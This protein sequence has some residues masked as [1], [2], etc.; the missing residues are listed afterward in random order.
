MV[1]RQAAAVLRGVGLDRWICRDGAEMVEKA[2][3]LTSDRNGLKQQRLQQR[4]QI[5]NSELLDHAGLAAT[6]EGSFRHWWLRWLQQEG[7]PT[8][9]QQ[10]AWPQTSNQED[11]AL[12]TPVSNSVNKRLPLWL[13]Y[14]PDMERQRLEAQGKRVIALQN[15]HPWGEA[16]SSFAKYR[17]DDVLVWLETGASEESLRWWQ[18]TY[19]QLLWELRGPLAPR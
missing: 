18:Q 2:L 1:S 13:G 10:Q 11:R 9:V 8:D 19:P 6:L 15:L 4:Q 16:V 3:S 5:A 17:P 14:L 12:L 7:W